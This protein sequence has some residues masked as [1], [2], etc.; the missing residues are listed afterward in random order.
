MLIADGGTCSALQGSGDAHKGLHRLGP[1]PQADPWLQGRGRELRAVLRHLAAG[2]APSRP[3][4]PKG[5]G[6]GGTGR[7]HRRRIPQEMVSV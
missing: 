1:Q 6:Q 5:P 2:T 7:G 3:W 4:H